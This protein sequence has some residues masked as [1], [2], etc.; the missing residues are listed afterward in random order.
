M[1]AIHLSPNARLGERNRGGG[2]DANNRG[3]VAA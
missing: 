1:L 3:E 2:A